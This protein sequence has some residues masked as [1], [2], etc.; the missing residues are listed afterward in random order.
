MT[1]RLCATIAAAKTKSEIMAIRARAR[2]A[3]R[4]GLIEKNTYDEILRYTERQY[5]A[6]PVGGRK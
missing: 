1:M 6:L 5:V 4:A 2:Y 3:Y